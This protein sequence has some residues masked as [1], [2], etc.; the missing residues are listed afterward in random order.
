MKVRNTFAFFV[1]SAV[2]VCS[3]LVM[4]PASV[5]SGALDKLTEGKLNLSGAKGTLWNG[6]GILLFSDNTQFIVLGHYNWHWSVAALLEGQVEYAVTLGENTRP[7]FLRISPLKQQAE[8]AHWHATLPAQMLSLLAPQLRAYQLSG[9]IDFSSDSLAFSGTGGLGKAALDWNHAGSGLTDIYPL[10][11]YRILIEVS[12]QD[13]SV[14]LSTL[15][16]VLQLGG[17]GKTVP[18]RGLEFSGTAQAGPGDQQ[19]VLTAL[20]HHMGPEISPGVFSF[21]LA[22]Q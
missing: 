10:G 4:A 16:G 15:G 7:M 19:V 18:G 5:L 1:F 12:G 11:D 2:F 3:L 13:M 21:G 14:Q 20:L 6:S 9:E 8:L 22:P 17:K